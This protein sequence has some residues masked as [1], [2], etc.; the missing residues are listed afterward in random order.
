MSIYI[1][2]QPIDD[3]ANGKEIKRRSDSRYRTTAGL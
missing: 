1:K 2:R 3:D